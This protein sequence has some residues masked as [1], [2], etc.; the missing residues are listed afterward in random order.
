MTEHISPENLSAYVDG[1]L[2]VRERQAIAEHLSV[3]AT[4]K[5]EVAALARLSGLLRRRP[6]FVAPPFFAT[7]LWAKIRARQREQSLAADFVWVAKRLLPALAILAAIVFAWTSAKPTNG[8][9]P[10]QAYLTAADST[11]FMNLLI[12]NGSELTP[13][14]VLQ[15]AVSE[16]P[17]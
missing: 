17:Q 11:A 2:P 15:L 6:D 12:Q 9:R 13:D 5:S 1:A 10:L 7:R 8:V 3:C 4:C 16:P 14:N